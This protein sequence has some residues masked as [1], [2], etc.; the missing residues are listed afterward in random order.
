MEQ[1]V[2]NAFG[3]VFYQI[4]YK[5]L[6]NIVEAEWHGTA[7]QRDLR[8]A[9]DVGLQMHERTNCAFRL[10]DNTSFSGPW[11][12]SVSWL[13]E[14]WLPRAYAAGIRY[15]AHVAREGSFGEQAGQVLRQGK[16]GAQLEVAIFSEKGAAIS[17]L[18][19]KQQEVTERESLVNVAPVNELN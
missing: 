4:A 9:L 15:L 1:E 5:S 13:E 18:L 19:S 11:A 6:S 3:R 17:W 10:N 7:T 14:E 2:R 12:D 8:N 16:I